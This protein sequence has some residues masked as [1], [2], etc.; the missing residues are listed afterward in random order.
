M[1]MALTVSITLPPPTA[2]DKVQVVFFDYL[3]APFSTKSHLGFG[4]DAAQLINVIS[5]SFKILLYLVQK[6][7]L[8]TEPPPYTTKT[9]LPLCF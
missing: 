8:L 4:N 6:P 1:Q 9:L 7:A 5:A 2:Q 3:D